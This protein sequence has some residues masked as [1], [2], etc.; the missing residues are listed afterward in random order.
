MKKLIGSLLV[1]LSLVLSVFGL[2]ACDLIKWGSGSD[3]EHHFTEYVETEATC[4][5]PGN[6][7]YFK[8]D[9]GPDACGKIFTDLAAMTPVDEKDVIRTVPHTVGA[10]VNGEDPT[11]TTAGTKAHYE[12]SSC[13]NYIAADA[14]TILGKIGDGSVLVIPAK[15]HDP[16]EKWTTDEK[17]HWHVCQTCGEK[18][19]EAAHDNDVVLEGYDETCTKPGLTSGTKCSVCDKV[20][21]PQTEIPAKNH[22]PAEAWTADKT[23]HWHECENGCGEKLEAANH[24]WNGDTCKTCNYKQLDERTYF[25]VGNGSGTIKASNWQLAPAPAAVTFKREAGTNIYKLENFTLMPGDEMKIGFASSWNAGNDNNSYNFGA[26]FFSNSK[27]VKNVNTDGKKVF[28]G[29]TAWYN[30]ARVATGM[31][32]IYTIT[33]ET[34]F[35]NTDKTAF[36]ENQ[37][38][39]LTFERTVKFETIEEDMGWYITGSPN[40]WNA[41]T[42]TEKYKLT[43]FSDGTW[44]G[45]F[46]FSGQTNEIKAIHFTKT[47]VVD[48]TGN[49][50]TYSAQWSNEKNHS[51]PAGTFEVRYNPSTDKLTHGDPHTHDFVWK[52][53]VDE[54]W[55]ICEYE[56]YE[57]PGSRGAHEYI[58]GVCKCGYEE[59]HEHNYTEWGFDGTQHWKIC[60]EDGAID[61]SSKQAHTTKNFACTTCGYGLEDPF[62]IVGVKSKNNKSSLYNLK[63]EWDETDKSL[64]FTAVEGEGNVFK[65]TVDLYEGDEFKI[66]QGAG[67]LHEI[68]TGSVKTKLGTFAG[69]G[70]GT[71][72]L[73][74]QAG[75]DG[76]YTITITKTGTGDKSYSMTYVCDEE[77]EVA[78]RPFE[79]YLTGVIAKQGLN[80]PSTTDPV[81]SKMIKLTASEDN[82]Y[83]SVKLE[84]SANDKIKIFKFFTDTKEGAYIP[85]GENNEKTIP[86]AGTYTIKWVVGEADFTFTKE[87]EVEKTYAITGV[88]IA[89]SEGK[90]YVTVTGTFAGY[91]A[92]EFEAALKDENTDELAFCVFYAGTGPEGQKYGRVIAYNSNL[93]TYTVE[94]GSFTVKFD[95]T[96]LDKNTYQVG[97]DNSAYADIGNLSYTGSVTLGDKKYD[98]VAGGNV[99]LTIA[100]K[101]DES[102][103]RALTGITL[104][105]D[106]GKVYLV[107]TGTFK[108][109]SEEDMTTYLEDVGTFYFWGNGGAGGQK[110][111][112]RAATFESGKWTL[113]FDVTDMPDD[114]EYALCWKDYTG[115]DLKPPLA[116]E[117]NTEQEVGNRTYTLIANA[118]NGTVRL[119]IRTNVTFTVTGTQIAEEG[120]KVV[121]TITG[122]YSDCTKAQ[123][124]AVLKDKDETNVGFRVINGGT[125]IDGKQNWDKVA[126]PTSYEVSDNGTFTVKIDVTELTAGRSYYVNQQQG[127]NTDIKSLTEKYENSVTV[128]TKTYRLVGDPGNN[129]T[130]FVT[131]TQPTYTFELTGVTLEADAT[132]VYVVYSGTHD[133]AD[134]AALKA[135]FEAETFEIY[136]TN[137]LFPAANR[138]VTVEETTWTIKAKVSSEL[139][140]GN[141]YIYFNG[142]AADSK[143]DVRLS[144]EQAKDGTSVELA[145]KKYTI[146]NKAEENWGCVCLKIEEAPA[147]AK[148]VTFGEAS[149]TAFGTE[150][151]RVLLRIDAEGYE[152][153][154]ENVKLVVGEQEIAVQELSENRYYFLVSKDFTKGAYTLKVKIGEEEFTKTLASIVTPTENKA[155][156]H[157][158]FYTLALNSEDL[159]LNVYK[160]EDFPITSIKMEGSEAADLVL[161]G[162]YAEIPQEV[163]ESYLKTAIGF[164]D[165]AQADV[166]AQKEVTAADGN[167]TLKIHVS[168]LFKVGDNKTLIYGG[169]SSD[170]EFTLGENKEVTLADGLTYALENAGTAVHLVVKNDSKNINY[171]S[172][173]LEATTDKVYLVF[174]GSSKGYAEDELKTALQNT[175]TGDATLPSFGFW[176]DAF[177]AAVISPEN[178]TV[179]ADSFDWEVKIDITDFSGN[180][181]VLW[182]NKSRGDAK[183]P[184]GFEPKTETVGKK[185]YSLNGSVG[186]DLALAIVETGYT[187]PDRRDGHTFGEKVSADM[188]KAPL[189]GAKNKGEYD[190]HGSNTDPDTWIYW[191]V[192]GDWGNGSIVTM[193]SVPTFAEGKLTFTY[194]GGSLD[195]SVQLFYNNTSLTVGK[196]YYLSMTLNAS[197]DSRI[198]VNGKAY[199]LKAGDNTI[200]VIFTLG[201]PAGVIDAIDIQFPGTEYTAGGIVGG[202]VTYALSNVTWEEVDPAGT[203]E[204]APAE[205]KVN[206]VYNPNLTGIALDVWVEVTGYTQNDL[207]GFVLMN[208]DVSLNI[209]PNRVEQNPAVPSQYHLF[210]DLTSLANGTYTLKLSLD[211]NT[212]SL[213]L[214]GKATVGEKDYSWKVQDGELQFTVADKAA[215]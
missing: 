161:T 204:P 85:N 207:E 71:G 79:V 56:G 196:Q 157:P 83:W 206:N 89:D 30:N 20:T 123:F 1:V 193:S 109:Y 2:A 119:K 117:S 57:N 177:V 116:G 5:K 93:I 140:D 72:N 32:G 68:N 180:Y 50:V 118:W 205:K 148:S 192:A 127:S 113:K 153:T 106:G 147:P 23:Q 21:K 112:S 81:A 166:N 54:H 149:V 195:W 10:L 130:L 45:T 125:I 99:T 76:K 162:T 12:C 202:T 66:I 41:T 124:E 199:N 115:N 214:E 188:A 184:E 28:E 172:V 155:F 48:A 208:G 33:L 18:V 80:W 163:V 212:W 77:F 86:A 47:T 143:G 189:Q 69:E 142:G 61:E 141:Y 49:K 40:G 183:G 95:V 24:T 103:E 87:V 29:S 175:D 121:V 158:S 102:K 55:Q 25:L 146:V 84:L 44:R 65:I 111:A 128:G 6:V 22:K 27:V 182:Q 59:D 211:G 43:E 134:T 200:G 4:D 213:S 168:A 191:Y 14:T 164:W 96:N 91:T 145:G 9:V 190:E 8:C 26:Y 170:V 92:T 154:K 178:V 152:L 75:K 132:A 88:A 51:I 129:A 58:E 198:K 15:G 201:G 120:G 187:E 186:N 60:P 17:T 104:T 82:T 78:A 215:E 185:A 62:Y 16:E 137:N 139:A 209:K 34:K 97:K 160:N 19:E 98:L 122:N 126:G 159:V 73:V 70:E 156:N 171:T 90:V 150:G 36:K 108:G 31:G 38:V 179:T 151:A 11:C 197:V 13:G 167:W 210:F 74:L 105:Q 169:G 144:D 42:P 100:D 35:A 194:G 133:Y 203:V 52:H 138:T 176:H 101:P 165:C 3:H 46:T 67:F 7:R 53:T 64:L 136:L 173:T 114:T 110:P 63:K 37:I 181:S 94:E 135:K 107:Y 131:D 39:S 174:K